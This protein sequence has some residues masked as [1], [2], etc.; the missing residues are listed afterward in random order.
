MSKGVGAEWEQAMRIGRILDPDNALY[1]AAKTS[2][3]TT[4]TIIA[5]N[6]NQELLMRTEPSL[7]LVV[8][9]TTVSKSSSVMEFDSR[10]EGML[11]AHRKREIADGIPPIID[12]EPHMGL[13]FPAETNHTKIRTEF[14]INDDRALTALRT[15]LDLALA[16]QEIG[17]RD[18]AREL[19]SEVASA[20][21]PELAKRAQSLLAQLA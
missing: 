9:D 17:D 13:D 10:L 18:G 4:Q 3:R 21:N 15:K 19:L 1:S 16:C 5:R 20:E 8:S 14:V 12:V 11:A 6:D 7:K 2:A